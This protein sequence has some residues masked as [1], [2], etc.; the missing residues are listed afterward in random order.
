MNTAGIGSPYWYE[1]EIG[2]FKCLEMLQ[3]EKISS[4]V[5]QSS[6][7]S[8][9]DDVVVKYTNGAS[10]NIQVKHTDADNNFTFSTLVG[11]KDPMLVK[12]AKEWSEKRAKYNFSEINIFT[13]KE[14]GTR[15]AD[16][17]CS[18]F[19]FVNK[20]LPKWAND[21]N[22]VSDKETENN[23]IEKI[24]SS[25]S[26]LKNDE[27]ADFIKILKFKKTSDRDKLKI[28]FRDK[29]KEV[30]GTDNEES[31]D[32]V[33]R[34]L[35]AQLH[36]WTTSLREKEEVDREDVYRVIC[37]KQAKL[38]PYNLIPEKPIFPSREKFAKE[39]IKKV[40]E[41]D[42]KIVFLQGYP[43]SGKTNFISYLA[44]LNNTIVDFR[45]YTYI[46]V[47]REKMFFSNDQGYF[48]GKDLWS[49]LLA[50]LKNKF[51]ELGILAKV[52]FPLVY[53]HMSISELKSTVNKFLSIYASMCNKTCYV[54]I[55]GLDHAARAKNNNETFLSQL[56]KPSE[57]STKV[58]YVFIGQP[59]N[60]KYPTWMAQTNCDILFYQLP[61]LTKEDVAMLLCLHE[62]NIDKADIDN[63][64]RC[65]I[66][67]VGNNAL[68]IHFA[69]YE[70]KRLGKNLN[71]DEI[72]D[73]LKSKKLNEKVEAYYEWII[74]SSNQDVIT[75]KII[76]IFAFITQ[77]ISLKDISYVCNM[78][79]LEV[80]SILSKMFPLIVVEKGLYYAYHND[81]KLYFKEKIASNSRCQ[82]IIEN[83]ENQILTTEKLYH[84]RYSFLF[85]ALQ[86]FDRKRLY[87][88]FDSKY[89]MN[90][91]LFDFSID[92]I[93][94]Q[95]LIIAK[96]VISDK[97]YENLLNV[98]LTLSTIFQYINCLRWN[99]K[100]EKVLEEIQ[101]E[102]LTESEKFI[103]NTNENLEQIINDIYFL[104]EN[105]MRQRARKLYE[106]YL[107][108]FGILDFKNNLN[109]SEHTSD[110]L[111]GKVGYICRLYRPKIFSTGDLEKSDFYVKF[112][113]G[114]LL[115][116]REFYSR[117][118]IKETLVFEYYRQDDLEEYIRAI[119][120]NIDVQAYDSFNNLA[121]T[122][123][124]SIIST[125]DLC[126]SEILNGY[127]DC[128][129][130]NY[131]MQSKERLFTEDFDY[132]NSQILYFIKWYFCIFSNFENID[133]SQL[134]EYYQK[135][136]DKKH[137]K[138]GNRG[139]APAQEQFN[140]AKKIFALYFNGIKID[141][142][143]EICELFSF[144][145]KYGIGSIHDSDS[146][147]TRTFLYELITNNLLKESKCEIEKLCENLLDLY[148]LPNGRFIKEF[149]PLFS[150]IKK[151]EWIEKILSHWLGEDGK[152]W[153]NSFDNIDSLCENL[154]PLM[155]ECGLDNEIDNIIKKVKLK[156]IGYVGRK[157]YSLYDP[158]KWFEQLNTSKEK[159]DL[160]LKLLAV[161]DI[162]D[163]IGDN[164]ASYDIERALF[165]LSIELGPKCVDALF[166]LKNNPDEFYYW[167]ERLL[168]EYY[169]YVEKNNMPDIELHALHK[170][171]N[172]WID[173]EIEKRIKYG[174]NKEGYLK[175]YNRLLYKK[176]RDKSLIDF[177]ADN[178]DVKEEDKSYTTTSREDPYKKEKDDIIR[179]A[180][181]RGFT[182]Q[183]KDMLLELLRK[184]DYSINSFLSE[185]GIV[186]K[187][188]DRKIFV[189]E[190]LLSY[191]LENDKYGFYNS[192]LERLIIEFAEYIGKEQYLLLFSHVIQKINLYNWD[193]LLG[194]SEDINT[195][196]YCFYKVFHGERVEE[197][198]KKKIGLHEL[199]ITAGGIL[200]LKSFKLNYD[201]NV[202]TLVDFQ[203]KHIG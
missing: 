11:I 117:E 99:A 56:P 115:A 100:D 103:L 45:F 86:F 84:L 119:L 36:I 70:L 159:L 33:E 18:F 17:C 54:F 121:K 156:I 160:G 68:N 145:N 130:I 106:E 177:D 5:F 40:T 58:K 50:Q 22:Y 124:L 76:C 104:S 120:G 77:K 66:E 72:I 113:S 15:R 51:Q 172:S 187:D 81:V 168:D 131:L 27:I 123:N 144:E 26:F 174:G 137:I 47:E 150:R 132:K 152:A 114:W 133:D 28:E 179:L 82:S 60:D 49:S 198:L 96:T 143:E 176:I 42:K 190:Y 24:K 186:L 127:V 94:N 62:I 199:W 80:E 161:S 162:A 107:N 171:V 8:S 90:S 95:F 183:V 189:S 193:S 25:L 134:N 41:T 184:D 148:T 157:D 167:R 31:I 20:V 164:R 180:S 73:E 166:E 158:L 52:K 165:K 195:L 16:G 155:R 2:L 175:K 122:G 140:I 34:N 74:N 202:N 6:Q 13:N 30:I 108:A 10:L 21:F 78:D 43:G 23:A 147:E 129:L 19:D 102:K 163:E 83:L 75:L 146:Y 197:V 203:K 109:I 118:K 200:K 111:I 7:F 139:Y 182:Q 14:F 188:E 91:I 39:F 192:G 88:L 97:E 128:S 44:Q 61:V 136:L 92:K 35:R 12:W 3:D 85:D 57:V 153:N 126:V 55:D 79:I 141:V 151:K 149:L 59:I 46:P 65:L 201:N 116:S 101:K 178:E 185:F 142:F 135:I 69:M 67:V 169:D 71:F 105:N 64:S 170:I 98:N 89:V 125:I 112:V 63:L 181:S 37:A 173:V 38:P 53:S 48:S 29:I 154:I 1:W 93:I 4:V 191:I 9:L 110:G 194:I 196:V 138:L 32:I 87:N